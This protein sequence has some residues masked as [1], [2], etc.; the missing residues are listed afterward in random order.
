MVMQSWKGR[1]TAAPPCAHPGLLLQGELPPPQ[2]RKYQESIESLVR[3]IIQK[4]KNDMANEII[5]A[6]RFDQTT[7]MDE[8]RANLE[9]L[10]QVGP[11]SGRLRVPRVGSA[12]RSSA[13]ARAY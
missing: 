10:L 11:R 3:N 5:D 7:T 6:G 13:R 1:A 8:R 12:A 4:H 9:A 2:E